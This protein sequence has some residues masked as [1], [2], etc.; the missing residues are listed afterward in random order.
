MN[1]KIKQFI[2]VVFWVVTLMVALTQL[3]DWLN[4]P[5]QDLEADISFS[6]IPMPESLSNEFSRIYELINF[7]SLR[8]IPAVQYKMDAL[9]DGSEKD[10]ADQILLEISSHLRRRIPPNLPT[11]YSYFNGCWVAMVRNDGSS[12]LSAVTIFLPNTCFTSITN[13]GAEPIENPSNEIINLG[14]LRPKETVSVLAWTKH[15]TSTY[16]ASTIRLTHS[17]GIGD[18]TFYAPTGRLGQLID[19]H[20]TFLFFL[21]PALLVGG[22]YWWIQWTLLKLVTTKSEN[23]P[24]KE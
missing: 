17:N 20:W 15:L 3:W 14:E 18:V 21:I 16:E 23:T 19:R 1:D 22:L 13:E 8:E 12:T 6:K 2:K 4:A 5:S 7:D 11:P 10:F 9:Q 24:A